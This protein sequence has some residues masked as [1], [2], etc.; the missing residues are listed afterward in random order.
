MSNMYQDAIVPEW[1]NKY[2][3]GIP[4]LDFQH[5]FFLELIKRF[6]YRIKSG[7]SMDLIKYHILEINLYAQFHFC[8]EENLMMLHAYPDKGTHK[9]L[10]TELLELL[11]NKSNLFELGKISVDDIS[12]F[13]VEWFV[14]HTIN[15]DIK[16]AMFIN[17]TN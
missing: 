15:E 13:L 3:I 7:I 17:R 1:C 4:E 8:S 10:H 6:H 14:T 9:N 12:S 11:A 2:E 16:L 5:K